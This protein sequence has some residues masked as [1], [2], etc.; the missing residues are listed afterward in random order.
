MTDRK[1]RDPLKAGHPRRMTDARCAW[2]RMSGEQRVE[3][4]EWIG[5]EREFTEGEAEY[6]IGLAWFAPALSELHD[7]ELT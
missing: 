7:E 4:L 3:F 5:A 2:N 6:V 1:K